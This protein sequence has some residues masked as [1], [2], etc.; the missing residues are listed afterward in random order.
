MEGYFIN[1]GDKT[2]S[3]FHA[4]EHLLPAFC[5][6]TFYEM[7]MFLPAFRTY[8]ERCTLFLISLIFVFG[9]DFVDFLEDEIG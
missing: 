4:A 9:N 2:R 7:R 3:A 1:V 6:T 8:V 5:L